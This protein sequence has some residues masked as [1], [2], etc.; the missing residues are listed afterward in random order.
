MAHELRDTYEHT[1]LGKEA[2][3]LEAQGAAWTTNIGY[4][5]HE[6]VRQ[7]FQAELHVADVGC[8]TGSYLVELSQELPSS[9]HFDGFDISSTQ[10]NNSL[11]D[12]VT[13]HV[14]DAKQPFSAE[15]HGKFDVVHLRLLVSAFSKDDWEPVAKNLSQLLKPGGAIQ[16]EEADLPGTKR[17]RGKPGTSV[18]ALD[19]ALQT[20]EDALISR[21]SYGFN[22]LPQAFK[23]VGFL[24][25]FQD[26]VSS[27]RIPETRE[28]FARVN[29]QACAGWARWMALERGQPIWAEQD[30]QELER[31]MEMEIQMGAYVRYDI[32]VTI[33]FKPRA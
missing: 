11:P 16:W 13:L 6:K 21:Y 8:G 5:L 17:L 4:H 27:D 3:R 29:V 2:Q 28:N 19:Y 32:Y 15:F 18:D 9:S 12:N 1:R 22:T 10:F 26:V 30:L 14:A 25:V 7:S 33:G 31:K 23:N 24:A 20:M